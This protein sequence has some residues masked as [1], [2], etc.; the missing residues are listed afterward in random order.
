MLDLRTQ[1][2][3]AIN[4]RGCFNPLPSAIVLALAIAVALALAS[5]IA[6]ADDHGARSDPTT[7]ASA[8]AEDTGTIAWGPILAG[9]LGVLFGA[10]IAVWHIRGSRQT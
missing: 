9:C 1:R 6:R 5:S 8:P 2:S 7:A 4:G 3:A 10:G